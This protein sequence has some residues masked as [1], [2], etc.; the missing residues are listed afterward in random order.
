MLEVQ[1][2]VDTSNH[3]T[4]EDGIMTVLCQ[5]G[6][7]FVIGEDVT[8]EILWVNEDTQH[9]E[10][11]VTTKEESYV[12]LLSPGDELIGSLD[13]EEDTVK[14]SNFCDGPLNRLFA[15]VSNN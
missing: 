7:K 4:M 1:I 10:V 13:D 3:L 14:P 11:R 9:V 15:R 8:L 5:A 2:S 6:D 12:E